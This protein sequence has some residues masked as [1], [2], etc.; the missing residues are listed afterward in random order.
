MEL[1]IRPFEKIVINGTVIENISNRIMDIKI[2]NLD[3]FLKSD[4][5]IKEQ[6]ANKNIINY[7]SFLSQLILIDNKNKY[8][9]DELKN[10]ICFLEELLDIDLSEINNYIDNDDFYHLIK[11]LKPFRRRY[12][13]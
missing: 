8:L 1:K 9:K 3:Y 7:I 4:D 12:K 11:I 6:D 10:I 5:L 13:Q 2:H